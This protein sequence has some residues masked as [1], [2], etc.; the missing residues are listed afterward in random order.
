MGRRGMEHTEAQREGRIRDLGIC[1]ICGSTDS[2]QGHH[3]MDYQFGGGVGTGYSRR[4]YTTLQKCDQ[5]N[6]DL[7]FHS[8]ATQ[9]VIY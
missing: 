1:Q 3:V 6:R 4:C 7:K 5:Q 2:P 9:R 8:S